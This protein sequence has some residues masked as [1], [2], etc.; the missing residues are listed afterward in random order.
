MDLGANTAFV[1]EPI[2]SDALAR[3]PHSARARFFDREMLTWIATSA[4]CMAACVLSYYGYGLAMVS[5]FVLLAFDKTKPCWSPFR[6]VS[7][8]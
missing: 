7:K 3:P 6:I 2:D 5:L 4:G 8:G 1:M